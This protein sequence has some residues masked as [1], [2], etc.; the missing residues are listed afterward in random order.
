LERER[1]LIQRID[2]HWN[3]SGTDPSG[4][5]TALNK[6][7]ERVRRTEMG[8]NT[9]G[10]SVSAQKAE[11]QLEDGTGIGRDESGF[12]NKLTPGEFA[13]FQA[14]MMKKHKVE[15]TEDELPV[16]GNIDEA[17][18]ED[19]ENDP[20]NLD[21]SMKW[22]SSRARRQMDDVLNDNPYSDLMPGDL[23]PTRLVNR[24]RAKWIPARLLHHNN[25]P[26]LRTFI[27][28]TGQIQNRVQTRLGARDQRIIS[29]LIKRARCLGLIP[30]AGQFKAEQHG[31]VHAKDIHDERPWEK[32]LV[33]RG[34][35]IK[36]PQKRDEE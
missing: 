9:L 36:R 29:R 1:H 18:E 22:L 34:L 33:R 10:R 5:P 28:E 2:E 13:S 21:L 35:V 8:L 31:W 6:F 19:D 4:F 23:S 16:L 25:I 17:Y 24:K 32:E 12:S 20:D 14:Y 30:V 11:D 26:L 15:V 7:A 3:E 27:T